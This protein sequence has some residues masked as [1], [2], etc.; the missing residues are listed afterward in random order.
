MRVLPLM[1]GQWFVV[2]TWRKFAGSMFTWKIPQKKRAGWI[3]HSSVRTKLVII[4]HL[5]PEEYKR[6]QHLNFV[7]SHG[8][9]VYKH[10]KKWWHAPPCSWCICLVSWCWLFGIVIPI[11]KRDGMLLLD[12]RVV[13]QTSCLFRQGLKQ[14]CTFYLTDGNQ[15]EYLW[16]AWFCYWHNGI[17]LVL[18]MGGDVC[19]LPYLQ[20]GHSPLFPLSYNSDV[21]KVHSKG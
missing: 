20:K 13:D 3:S 19:T 7:L 15:I 18:A 6:L 1:L 10:E 9:A 2:L 12:P 17:I 8:L 5:G 21:Y 14:R 11:K 16:Y 4:R